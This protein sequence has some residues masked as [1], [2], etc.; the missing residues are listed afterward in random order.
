LLY[1]KAKTPSD[2]ALVV[3]PCLNEKDY[4]AK[5]IGNVLRDPASQSSLIVVADGG[6]TDGTTEIV[7]R[8]ATRHPNVRL[9]ANPRRI[10]GAG[11]NLAARRFGAGRR[12]LVRMDAHAEYPG[13]FVSRVITD[14]ER[15]GATS[16]VVAMKSLGTHCFQRAVAVAQ[17]SVLGS[18]G[19]PHRRDGVEGYVDHGH[20]AL[21][22]MRSFLAVQ[23]YDETQSHNEDAELDCRLTRYGGRIWLTGSACIGYYPR[24]RVSELYRQY[25]NYGRGRAT[26]LLRHRNGIKLRQLLPAGV[27]PSLILSLAGPWVP[28]AAAPCLLW[29][30]TCLLFGVYLGVRER[31]VCAFGS[32]VAAII[33][34]FAW[35][36][37]FCCATVEAAM[38]SDPQIGFSREGAR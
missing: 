25:R 12:W 27:L 38:R 9:V 1:A 34:H 17:N 36:M 16:V 35:S 14:A 8:I 26:T 15:T 6:S 33:M 22:D 30:A 19:S 2:G 10:Q 23:G 4:I 18:G 31:S 21:I 3:I 11:I 7:S 28:A 13:A 37:G 32:G 24:G 29:V 5:V 20:H